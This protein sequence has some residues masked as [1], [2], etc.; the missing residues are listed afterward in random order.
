MS[1]WLIWYLF[2]SVV[3]QWLAGNIDERVLAFPVGTAVGLACLGGLYVLEREYGDRPW[4]GRLRSARMSCL[5]LSFMVL[6]CVV[7]GCLPA[8]VAFSTSWPF[9]ALVAGVLVQ[10]T[11]VVL[12]RLG[13]IRSSRFVIGR[14]MPFLLVH[15]GLWLALAA[16]VVGAGDTLDLRLLSGREHPASVAVD[17]QG[18]SHPLGYGIQ[19][20]DFAVETSP[21]DGSPVQYHA[22]LLIDGSPVRLSVND[23]YP[24]RF[25]EDVYLASYDRTLSAGEAMPAFCILQIVRQ[26]SK[27]PMLLGIVMLLFG[28]VWRVVGGGADRSARLS[29]ESTRSGHVQESGRRPLLLMSMPLTA[30]MAAVLWPVHTTSPWE[31]FPWFSAIAGALWLSGALLAIGQGRRAYLWSLGSTALGI[32]VYGFFVVMLWKA[33]GRP[34]LRTMGETR[35]WYSLFM[36]VSG[37]IVYARWRYRWIPLFSLLV[38]AVFIVINIVRPELH[39]RSLMPALQSLWFVPHVTV[40]MF[41]YSLFGCAFLLAVAGIWKKTPDYLPSADRL[42]YIG[43][44]FLTFGMLSG[45]LWAKQAWGT[46]WSWDPKETWAAAT[47]CAYLVYV[48]RRLPSMSQTAPPVLAVTGM[49]PR[50]SSARRA[51]YIW[52][53][54]GFLLLQMCWYGVNLLPSASA[55]MHSYG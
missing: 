21:L 15:M 19:L 45:C 1:I 55:S 5:L 16:G 24:V 20:S 29:G 26:P 36:A 9:V 34:P 38:A 13:R 2:V 43:L 3:L 37:W 30:L 28:I 39:D 23:P 10:L 40:Y 18:R 49:P 11:L 51:D 8:G 35:L 33:L 4:A 7:C 52:L 17:A 42:V 53:V 54:V 6:G 22:T 50:L 31:L 14:D 44:V 27:Y 12:H 47:W 25:S 41:S 48:H 32:A 46:Y